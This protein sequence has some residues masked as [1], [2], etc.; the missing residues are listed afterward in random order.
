MRIVFAL[1]F[2]FTGASAAAEAP[3]RP[4]AGGVALADAADGIVDR[5]HVVAPPGY[6]YV[7]SRAPGHFLDCGAGWQ[8][9]AVD[10]D[11]RDAPPLY[12]GVT[13]R[14]TLV[15]PAAAQRARL[16]VHY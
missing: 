6:A 11:G 12:C 3:A 10:A 5:A 8:A 15:A 7:V 13:L 1:A 9:R 2:L 14:A 4:A 16:G